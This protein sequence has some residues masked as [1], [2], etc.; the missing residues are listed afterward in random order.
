MRAIEPKN[1]VYLNNLAHNICRIR[2]Q[3][4]YSKRKMAEL[5]RLAPSDIERIERGDIPMDMSVEVLFLIE[6]HFGIHP[7]DLFSELSS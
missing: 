5:L 6:R 4:G 1:I 3:Y 2:R 7:K